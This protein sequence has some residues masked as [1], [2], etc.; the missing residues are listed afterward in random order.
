MHCLAARRR[1]W[2]MPGTL[3]MPA[4]TL[5][6]C[7]LTLDDDS[8]DDDGKLLLQE[9]EDAEAY[10]E[11]VRTFD[12]LSVNDEISQL[13]TADDA[14]R[15]MHTRV[16]PEVVP[17]GTF[18]KRFFFYRSLQK[19]KHERR[20]EL[21]R[22]A[23]ELVHNEVVLGWG[24]DLDL[25]ETDTGDAGDAEATTSTSATAT[26]TAEGDLTAAAAVAAA[27]PSI[28]EDST[29][30][31]ADE[32]LQADDIAVPSTPV[33]VALTHADEGAEH[34]PQ[35]ST[36]D[37]PDDDGAAAAP[38]TTPTSPSQTTTAMS[39][40]VAVSPAAAVTA[41]PPAEEEDDWSAWS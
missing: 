5:I 7:L 34:E 30:A 10:A 12:L 38:V 3:A 13:L 37:E 23:S 28:G 27:A 16:V 22:K 17:Y 24:D 40:T 19:R 9:P 2:A 29:A 20:Q 1:C 32:P 33:A 11:F 36:I 14:L 15:A 8:R 35:R 21:I 41:P 31:P 18:W 25:D 26:T 6:A 39:A 4:A